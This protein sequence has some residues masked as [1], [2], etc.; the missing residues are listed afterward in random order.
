VDQDARRQI[1]WDMQEKLFEDRPYIILT[2]VPAAEAYRSDRF[3]FTEI[4]G[5]FTWKLCVLQAEPLK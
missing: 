4:C 1:I 2:Y 5:G 3:T